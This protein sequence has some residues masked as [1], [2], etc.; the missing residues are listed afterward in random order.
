MMH[1][2]QRVAAGTLAAALAAGVAA[3]ATAQPI[4]VGRLTAARGLHA[5]RVSPHQAVLHGELQ[6]SDACH[7]VRFQVAPP[8]IVPP[9][10]LAQQYRYRAGMCAMVVTWQPASIVF[11]APIGSHRVQ[12]HATNGTFT[13]S[14]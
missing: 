7:R 9:I 3:T 11:A 1:L 4:G 5:H 2:A 10:I 8:T 12:V 6:S 13:I 14:Y